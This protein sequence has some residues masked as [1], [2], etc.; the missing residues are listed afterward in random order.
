MLKAGFYVMESART[1]THTLC[2]THPHCISTVSY[3]G[4]YMLTQQPAPLSTVRLVFFQWGATRKR[5]RQQ[6]QRNVQAPNERPRCASC[7]ARG[8][9]WSTAWRRH[10]RWTLTATWMSCSPASGPT[11]RSGSSLTEQETFSLKD[12][13]DSRVQTKWQQ[14]P[15][16]S[17]FVLN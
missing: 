2:L 12:W 6:L 14:D 17:L 13:Q 7:M 3:V 8:Q 16:G 11:C 10:S 1:Y 9:P 4:F 15:H 5:E